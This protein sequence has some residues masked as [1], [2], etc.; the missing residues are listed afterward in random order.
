MLIFVPMKK[1]YGHLR[2]YNSGSNEP[3]FMTFP[4]GVAKRCTIER[5]WPH[6]DSPVY[7]ETDCVDIQLTSPFAPTFRLNLFSTKNLIISSNEIEFVSDS[8][9]KTAKSFNLLSDTLE[10][11]YVLISFKHENAYCN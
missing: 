4:L 6:I 11:K 3:N 1:T 8:I 5:I 9:D 2:L 7:F 10:H